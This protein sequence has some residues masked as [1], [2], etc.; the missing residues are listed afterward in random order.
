[1]G[2]KVECAVTSGEQPVGFAVGPALE[3]REAL[4][5]LMG[6]GPPDLKDK[7]TAI[8]GILLEMVGVKEG[9]SESLRIIESG[10]AEK[11]LREIIEVQ[12][13]NPEVRPEDVKVGDHVSQICSEEGGVI[14]WIDNQSIAQIAKAAGAPKDK[15]AG[16]LLKVKIGDHVER[17]GSIFEVYAE[18]A[19]RLES[20]LSLAESLRPMGIGDKFG[21]D[22]LIDQIPEKKWHERFFFIER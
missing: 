10:K 5:T 14:L 9:R 7:A 13:G 3:A 20:A 21:R 11:K 19:S 15:G 8:S 12:G 4:S 18:N 17:K 1:L 16:V 22:M 2:I 6:D